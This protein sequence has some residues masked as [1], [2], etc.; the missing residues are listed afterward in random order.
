MKRISFL[1]G[2]VLLMNLGALCHPVSPMKAQRLAETFWQQ[3][4]C[5]AR[6][7]LSANTLVDIT[8]QTGFSHFQ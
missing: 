6:S 2:L 5:A 4:G 1:I 8:A 7:G 3:S